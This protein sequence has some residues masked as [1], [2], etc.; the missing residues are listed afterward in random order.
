MLACVILVCHL[1]KLLCD[2][3]LLIIL[4]VSILP[5]PV[6]GNAVATQVF[7]VVD[8]LHNDQPNHNLPGLTGSCF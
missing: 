7:T 3:L 8:R 6:V 2:P 4:F 1:F 5:Q